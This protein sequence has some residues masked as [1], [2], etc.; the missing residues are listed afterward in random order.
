LG[1]KD[2]LNPSGDGIIIAIK[3]THIERSGTGRVSF[4]LFTKA[5]LVTDTKHRKLCLNIIKRVGVN[6]INNFLF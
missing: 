4:S 1:I 2:S 5:Y 3:T 6:V